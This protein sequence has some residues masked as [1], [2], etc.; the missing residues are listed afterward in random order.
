MPGNSTIGRKGYPRAMQQAA[1]DQVVMGVKL[2]TVATQW[3]IS[4][5]TLG[6]WLHKAGYV[7]RVVSTWVK[8]GP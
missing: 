4:P 7:A 2:T 5:V 3:H 6:V 1:V 8:A